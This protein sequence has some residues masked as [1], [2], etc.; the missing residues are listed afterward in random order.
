[1]AVLPDEEVD[2]RLAERDG[3]AREGGA[4]V[5]RFTREGGF[6]GSVGFVNAITEPAE[7]MNHH[8]DLEIAWNVVTVRL[9]THS[10]GGITEKDL[11]LADEI[12]R[13][14]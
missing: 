10:E 5:K 11:R 6:M 1:M 14:P 3:W 12:D 8:P 4:I 7:R 13:I 2:R 9:A